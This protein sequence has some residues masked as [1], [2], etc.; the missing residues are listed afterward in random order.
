MT[1]EKK[2]RKEFKELLNKY[3]ATIYSICPLV[4][5]QSRNGF[6]ISL[7]DIDIDIESNKINSDTL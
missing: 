5:D 6:Q 3:G 4:S 2:F 7:N 1:Q